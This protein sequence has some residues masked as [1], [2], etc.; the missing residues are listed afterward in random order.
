MFGATT[1]ARSWHDKS[2]LT[3]WPA[4]MRTRS[5]PCD[6]R[7]VCFVCIAILAMA[8]LSAAAVEAR[9]SGQLPPAPTTDLVLAGGAL[10]FCSGMALRHCSEGTE[11]AVGRGPARYRL[12]AE[13]IDAAAD[14]Q[15]WRAAGAQRA[16]DIRALLNAAQR[17]TGEHALSED[18]LLD[19]FEA[20]CRRGQRAP[21]LPKP[22]WSQLD[23]YERGGLLSALEQ[24]QMTE[25]GERLREQV[26]LSSSHD[27]AGASILRA[28][29]AAAAR[30]SVEKPR[31]AVVTASAFDSMD[32]VDVYLAA[33]REAGGDPF[34]WPIDQAVEHA[35]FGDGECQQLDT[36][37]VRVLGVAR[38][39]RVYPDH[40][41]TQRQWCAS[42]AARHLPAG[43]HGVF[44]SGGDKWRLRQALV[45]ESDRPNAWLRELQEAFR[46]G[47]IAVGGTSAGSAVQS[48]VVMI[49]NGTSE[50]ALRAPAKMGAPPTPGCARAGRCSE[51]DEDALSAWPAGGLG[52]SPFVVDTH[53]SERS[54]EWRLLALLAQSGATLGLGVDETSALHLRAQ[55][56]NTLEIEALGIGGG[57]LYSTNDSA[58]GH[59]SV[60]ANY[61]APGH[62]LIWRNGRADGAASGPAST[63]AMSAERRLDLESGLLPSAV[64]TAMQALVAEDAGPITFAAGSVTLSMSRSAFTHAYEGQGKLRSVL[65]AQIDL[66]WPQ[67][68]CVTP[69]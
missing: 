43:V 64:R 22:L 45:D 66:R 5:L 67:N 41:E 23:D 34:W 69:P 65:R 40:A 11:L 68:D 38:R 35:I 19:A 8:S 46:Q 50:A 14:A 31:V 47:S 62:T 36:A 55:A 37:R 60:E 63:S 6:W 26:S 15:L 53:F 13:T 56:D 33:L 54:R 17:K 18:A 9:A 24:P 48:M 3:S 20:V 28:F 16:S 12:T 61:L 29:V 44:F 10:N 49:G 4:Y 52:L 25:R 30:R 58:C 1:S 32:A 59:I 27:A 7:I 42:E 51:A 57:W 39:E 2:E 21:C